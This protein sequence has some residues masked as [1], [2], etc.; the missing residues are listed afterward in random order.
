MTEDELI[1]SGANLDRSAWKG[2]PPI[3]GARTSSRPPAASRIDRGALARLATRIDTELEARSLPPKALARPSSKLRPTWA[4]IV[5]PLLAAIA[6]VVWITRI[7][8]DAPLPTYQLAI[9][10]APM[11]AG[12]TFAIVARPSASPHGAI[13][14]HVVFV[15][16]GRAHPW[17]GAIE[18]SP[19]GTLR[20]TGSTDATFDAEG[21]WEV[22]VAIGRPGL[23]PSNAEAIARAAVQGHPAPSW[24]LARDSFDVEP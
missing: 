17:T 4:M 1:K 16:G 14:A 23:V 8:V 24:Q 21:R 13:E 11:Q 2:T 10:P 12:T 7:P 6:V 19:D 20:V 15:H 9:E 18:A 22:D 5:A 3:A